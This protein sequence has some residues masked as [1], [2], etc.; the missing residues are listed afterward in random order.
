MRFNEAIQ[1]GTA[2]NCSGQV[3]IRIVGVSGNFTMWVWGGSEF[4]QILHTLPQLDTLTEV[5]M[6]QRTSN[7]D[8]DAWY[9]G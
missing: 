8:L 2:V 7:L 5:E 3:P 4:I 9:E 6:L 1:S